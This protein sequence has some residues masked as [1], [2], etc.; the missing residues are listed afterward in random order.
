[1]IIREKVRAGSW[2]V[3]VTVVLAAT[4]L[5]T[6]HVPEFGRQTHSSPEPSPS[7]SRLSGMSP[8]SPN[9]KE[10]GAEFVGAQNHVPVDGR[11]TT[12]S[13][14]RSLSR[15]AR[16]GMSPVRPNDVLLLVEK[17]VAA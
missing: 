17:P 14:F 7:I 16:T 13:S 8:V 2:G 5:R 9:C 1:M 10:P 15:S 12:K 4:R 11:K 6:N 3:A